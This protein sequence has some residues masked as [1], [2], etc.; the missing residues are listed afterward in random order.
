MTVGGGIFQSMKGVPN[1]GKPAESVW[2]QTI[3]IVHL[4]FTVSTFSG[5]YYFMV[6][7]VGG[8]IIRVFRKSKPEFSKM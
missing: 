4:T 3:E 6:V 5:I 7:N 2:M 1:R 8:I